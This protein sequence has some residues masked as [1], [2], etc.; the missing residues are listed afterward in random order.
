V[1]KKDRLRRERDKRG[2]LHRHNC[3]LER[4]ERQ[5]EIIKKERARKIGGWPSREWRGMRACTREEGEKEGQL[6]REPASNATEI[7]NILSDQGTERF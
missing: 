7:G 1:E 2:R 5:I 4:F 6:A 3:E